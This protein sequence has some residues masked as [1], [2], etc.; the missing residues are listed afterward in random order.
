ML[1]LD[2]MYPQNNAVAMF[3]M[4][5]GKERRDMILE[6]GVS[7]VIIGIDKDYIEHDYETDS[8]T[9][10]TSYLHNVNKIANLFHGYCKVTVLYDKDD[11]LGYKDAPTDR[12]REIYEK[13]YHSRMKVGA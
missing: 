5:L 13:L 11:D 2:S 10:F 12:G 4:N 8:Q 6:L 9:P 3:G 7:E 1:Q